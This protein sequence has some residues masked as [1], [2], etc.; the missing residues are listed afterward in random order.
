MTEKPK[1]ILLIID[2]QKDFT[3]VNDDDYKGTMSVTGAAEDYKRIIKFIETNEN[4]IDEIHVTL[5]THTPN[6]IGHPSYWKTVSIDSNGVAKTYPLDNGGYDTM[7]FILSLNNGENGNLS[8]PRIMATK[9]NRSI[10][11]TPSDSKLTDYTIKYL[12]ALAEKQKQSAFIW[13]KHCIEGSKG[14]EIADSLKQKLDAVQNKQKIKVKY[15]IKGQNNLAEMY[16]IFSAEVP[17]PDNISDEIKS[18]N[19]NGKNTDNNAYT[20]DKSE[21]VDTYDEVITKVNLDTDI[22]IDLMNKL[23]GEGNNKVFVCG[24]AKTHCVKNSIIDLMKYSNVRGYNSE[25]I[26]LI[27]DCTSPIVA[28]GIDDDIESIVISPEYK[29]KVVIHTYGIANINSSSKIKK[30]K[31]PNPTFT[32]TN[33]D[34]DIPNIQKTINEYNPNRKYI[35]GKRTRKVKKSKKTRKNKKHKKHHKTRKH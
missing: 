4:A 7:M 13:D 31:I 34:T 11:V 6:H 21:G 15:H 22:N 27:K 26:Y 9:D 8:T 12:Q 2:P 10:Q 19:Y 35:G 25:N 14:H 23:L 32:G 16:S 3:D 29:K 18:V 5:D 30:K 1:N 17:V 24:E 28:S 20:Y 33:K